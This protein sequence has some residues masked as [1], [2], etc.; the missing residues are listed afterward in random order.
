MTIFFAKKGCFE[1]IAVNVL[2][3][4]SLHLCQIHNFSTQ[5]NLSN[6]ILL[7][8]RLVIYAKI[9]LAAASFL[10]F[11]VL[12]RVLR[13][14][15]SEDC[16]RSLVSAF[17]NW[18]SMNFMAVSWMSLQCNAQLLSNG[19]GGILITAQKS[20]PTPHYLF[21]QSQEAEACI[22]WWLAW[23]Y[24]QL[25]FERK[26]RLNYWYQQLLYWE[27]KLFFLEKSD[28]SKFILLDSTSIWQHTKF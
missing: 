23:A 5:N 16:C 11:S 3:A 6:T 7:L 15:G 10:A 24:Y 19:G 12:F 25:G 20:P 18:T 14:S 21:S 8:Y 2:L 1:K 26:N 28:T 22:H 27:L 9:V 13:K 4:D 17:T